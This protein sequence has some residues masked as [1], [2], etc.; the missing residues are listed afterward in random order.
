[1]VSV[2]RAERDDETVERVVAWVEMDEIV[3]L[4]TGGE[5]PGELSAGLGGASR[6]FGAGCIVGRCVVEQTER[7]LA[8]YS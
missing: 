7:D 3:S 6:R 1:M 4:R 2:E 8:P 5:F